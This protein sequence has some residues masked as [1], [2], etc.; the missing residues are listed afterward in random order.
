MSGKVNL[1]MLLPPL[2]L[3]AVGAE[4]PSGLT[5]GKTR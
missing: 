4:G 5:R 3:V 1:S 2:L